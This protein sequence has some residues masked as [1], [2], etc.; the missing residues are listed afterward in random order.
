L[1]FLQP[2]DAKVVSATVDGREV[3][4]DVLPDFKLLFHAPPA[5]GLR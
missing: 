1:V 2:L 4:A 5:D 3:P